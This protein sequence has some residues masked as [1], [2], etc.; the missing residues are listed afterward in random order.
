MDVIS[1]KKCSNGRGFFLEAMAGIVDLFNPLRSNVL[2]FSP[3]YNA[4]WV[5]EMVVNIANVMRL[6]RATVLTEGE[7]VRE[8]TTIF[9]AV[10]HEDISKKY[11]KWVELWPQEHQLWLTLCATPRTMAPVF[12]GLSL[13]PVSVSSSSSVAMLILKCAL[14]FFLGA[15]LF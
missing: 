2:S 13:A 14:F 4:A 10:T 11:R 7:L 3:A 1:G 9:F 8:L 15:L 6:V 12:G 5:Q